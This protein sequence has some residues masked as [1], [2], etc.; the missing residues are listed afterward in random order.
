MPADTIFRFWPQPYPLPVI[1]HFFTAK[2]TGSLELR[3][4]RFSA[5]HRTGRLLVQP[6][7]KHI[8]RC[9]SAV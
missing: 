4:A 7:Y 8:S 3:H 6:F 5:V 1:Y 9:I 2:A